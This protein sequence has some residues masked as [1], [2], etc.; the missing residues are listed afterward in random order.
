MPL[1]ES[2]SPPVTFHQLV[3]GWQTDWM[4]LVSLCIEIGIAAWYVLSVIRLARRGRQWSRWRTASFLLGTLAVVV[5][6]QS[7]LASYDDSVF[8]VHVVQHLLLMNVAPILYAL[9]APVTL[10]LQ[11]S[12]RKTQQRLLSV[13]HSK[14]VEF[15]TH[16]VLVVINFSA[17]MLFFF[18]TPFYQFSLEHPLLHE[19][20]HLHFLVSGILYWW[21]VV[22][23]DPSRWRL[24]FPAKL[25]YLAVGVPVSAILG[26]ALTESRA[27]IAPQFHTVADTHAGG[28]ILWILGELFTLSA[29]AI[30]FVQWMRADIREAARYDRRNGAAAVRHDGTAIRSELSGREART[31]DMTVAVTVVNG[32]LV[33]AEEAVPGDPPTPPRP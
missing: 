33:A 2:L 10:T 12:N 19:F 3:T 26:L 27:S 29:L 1:A 16:P 21:L 25:G 23:I 14:P 20:T 7:G 9:A 13:L 5:A 11:A 15:I 32:R 17:T 22:G 28:A 4:S 31:A 18:L 6:V 30:I 8:K 24:S